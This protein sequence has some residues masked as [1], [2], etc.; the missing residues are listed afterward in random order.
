MAKKPTVKDLEI[1]LEAL[2]TSHEQYKTALFLASCKVV[3]ISQ[4]CPNEL[5]GIN[6]GSCDECPGGSFPTVTDKE[7]ACMERYFMRKA[8]EDID[9]REEA[10]DDN[11]EVERRPED[12]TGEQLGLSDGDP[13]RGPAA[14]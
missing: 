14:T 9:A 1:E 10:K 12:P 7:D 13:A 3:E 4:N 6:F 11:S 8:N 2:K 5:Y